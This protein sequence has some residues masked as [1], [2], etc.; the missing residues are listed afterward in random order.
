MDSE[1]YRKVVLQGGPLDGEQKTVLAGKKF[2]TVLKDTGEKVVYEPT[3]SDP[4]V[5]VYRS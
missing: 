5:L 1:R 4:L 3:P 2:M